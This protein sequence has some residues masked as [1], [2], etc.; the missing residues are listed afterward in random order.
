MSEET[1]SA[2][3]PEG[4][5]APDTQAPKEPEVADPAEEGTEPNEAQDDITP[6]E[7][8]RDFEKDAAFAEMRRKA[9]RSEELEQQL[10]ELKQQQR[11][12]EHDATKAK[13]LAEVERIARESG[14][15]DEEVQELLN[16]T[17][18]DLDKDLELK[19]RDDIID[20]L[21]KQNAAYEAAVEAN[22]TLK[23]IQKIDPTVK[24]LDDLGEN[25][26]KFAISMD[27]NGERLLTPEQ[28]YFACKAYENHMDEITPVAPKAPGEV[29]TDAGD[30]DFYTQ[31]EVEAMSADE[32][33]RNLDKINASSTRWFKK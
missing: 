33:R 12:A 26:P 3:I 7:G 25:F 5:A 31:E 24:D 11:T 6:E 8:E 2:N 13:K 18:S 28:A 14:L 4:N 27:G 21:Q 29:K 10:A 15:S 30:K 32:I 17:E 9:E 19:N 23:A 20:Q 22:D 16:D 1:N